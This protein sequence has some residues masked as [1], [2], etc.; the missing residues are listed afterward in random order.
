MPVHYELELAPDY[1]DGFLSIGNFD[2]VHRGHQEILGQLVRQAHTAGASACVLTFEP[3]PIQLLRPEFTPPRLTTLEQKTQLL[4]ER[5]VDNV[6][7]YPT[8]HALLELDA[9]EFFDRIVR[10]HF[11][12]R[13]LTE[14]PNF[15][16][17]KN[18]SGTIETLRSLCQREQMS[19]KVVEPALL[20]G[21]MVSSTAIRRALENG[22]ISEANRQLGRPYSMIGKISPGAQRGR[23]LGFPTANL[24]EIETLIPGDGVYAAIA[25]LPA[26]FEQ[27][28]LGQ[29]GRGRWAAAVNIGSNPTFADQQRKVEAHL[30][31]FA[32][33][34]YGM[35]IELLFLGRIREVQTFPSVETLKQQVRADV[36]A[37]RQICN[38]FSLFDC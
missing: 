32:G 2:G 37:A 33:D 11:A 36:D 31:E 19:L 3:H 21:E 38:G 12:A 25:S 18:R 34:L 16:F 27:T 29:R 4:L 22:E 15:C 13:G 28:D 10:G 14:G 26:G 35:E 9:E 7:V 1:R 30:I 6:V 5:G 24:E 20:D 17:G 8:D 23:T